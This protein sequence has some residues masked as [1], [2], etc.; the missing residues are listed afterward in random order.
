[1]TPSPITSSIIRSPH[2]VL[3]T[4]NRLHTPILHLRT[5]IRHMHTR[6]STSIP[7]PSLAIGWLT[8]HTVIGPG[9]QRGGIRRKG[10][11]DQHASTATRISIRIV[12]TQSMMNITSCMSYIFI[13]CIFII[14]LLCSLWLWLLE[15]LPWVSMTCSV[16]LLLLPSLSLMFLLLNLSWPLMLLRTPH[17]PPFGEWEPV[18]HW[19]G[20][21]RDR[22]RL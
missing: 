8:L 3:P 18:H 7:S 22:S 13:S 14:S 5:P 9:R 10:A 2:A 4:L 19:G 20:P 21:G 1:M 6:Y 11:S 12:M 16:I 15:L 17:T